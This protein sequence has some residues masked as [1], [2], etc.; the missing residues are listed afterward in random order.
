[1]SRRNLDGTW[2]GSGRSWAKLI[3]FDIIA[4]WMAG[5]AKA[6]EAPKPCQHSTIV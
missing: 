1:M 5:G 3:S 2:V 6:S 4:L